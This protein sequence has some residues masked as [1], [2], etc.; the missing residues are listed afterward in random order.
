ME[1]T[2]RLYHRTGRPGATR[3]VGNDE[4][5][6]Y[7]RRVVRYTFTAPASG[8]SVVKLTIKNVVFGDGEH[9]PLR[10]YLGFDPEDHANA[11]P[12]DIYTGDLTA[13]E[14][15]AS[16]TGTA[17]LILL[18]G[19]TYYLWVFPATDSYGYYWWSLNDED[20]V[21][22]LSGG[23]CVVPVVKNGEIENRL[24]AV[25]KGGTLWL[26]MPVAVIGGK[27]WIVGAGGET[28]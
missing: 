13:G 18:P 12:D 8:A 9:I 20:H 28:T 7:G 14:D 16:F 15:G 27:P 19:K 4:G 3:L 2:E 1:L 25:A 6:E 5:N 22:E 21:L 11:G 10:F 24:L 26:C 23:A 17:R